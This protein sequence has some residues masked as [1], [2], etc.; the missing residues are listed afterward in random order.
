MVNESGQLGAGRQRLFDGVVRTVV[1][2]EEDLLAPLGLGVA[3]AGLDDI[4]LEPG[5]EHGEEPE[6][7]ERVGVGA[8]CRRPATTFGSACRFALV[9]AT[10]RGVSPLNAMIDDGSSAYCGP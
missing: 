4:T 5:A 7:V 10:W 1:V 9:V 6:R 3:D 8:D 2:D